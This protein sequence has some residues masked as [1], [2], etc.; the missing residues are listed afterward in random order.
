MV[1]VAAEAVA[2]DDLDSLCQTMDDNA[3]VGYKTGSS[4]ASLGSQLKDVTDS[5]VAPPQWPRLRFQLSV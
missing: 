5:F 1:V 4:C 3:I 2:D